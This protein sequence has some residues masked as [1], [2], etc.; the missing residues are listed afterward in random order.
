VLGV[1]LIVGA[2]GAA[3]IHV[4]RIELHHA[5]TADE[6]SRAHLVAQSG[7]E[8]AISMI[9]SYDDW[10]EL[11]DSGDEVTFTNADP[12]NTLQGTG[13]FSLTPLDSDDDLED[14]DQDSVTLRSVGT[15]GNA[16]SVVEVLLMPAGD[17]LGCLSSSMHSQGTLRVTNSLET[18]QRVSANS[19]INATGGNINGYAASTVVPISGGV[20]ES[21]KQQLAN[22]LEMPNL[23]NVFE[24]YKT[25]G[26][27]IPVGS[28][29]GGDS[30]RE[31]LLSPMSNPYGSGETN[32]QGVY[33]VDCQGVSITLR[34]CRIV[35]T[36]V[37]LNAGS[38]TNIKGTIL[39]EPAI[40][41]FPVL[42]VEGPL[43]E[44]DWDYLNE[45]DE[46]NMGINLNP[47]GLP[48]NGVVD[49]LLGGIWEG[50]IK[51]LVY[52]TGNL[53]VKNQTP[54]IDGVVVSG[55]TV[56]VESALKLTY[57]ST[58]LTNPPP[59]FAAGPEM[60]IVQGTW[61]RVA[62]P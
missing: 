37:L 25:N 47:V 50:G 17:G 33:V 6:M 59:G 56:N 42:M 39:M 18:N 32:A 12:R 52:L 31:V 2:L 8:Y 30:I 35:G 51:G 23:E 43:L 9:N 1:A 24:Y 55:G 29:S 57:D 19:S 28:L 45:L 15:A 48:L 21:N 10:R 54:K 36:L 13:S 46:G 44:M 3:A 4:V 26:T 11:C 5:V 16:T 14:N 20:S 38:G 61:K 49:N 53:L 27:W 62:L 34:E 41:N 40:A 7:I 22:P 60:Q 58:F